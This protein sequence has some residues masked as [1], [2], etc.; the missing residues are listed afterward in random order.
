MPT[1]SPLHIVVFDACGLRISSSHI[2][3][4][5]PISAALQQ[6]HALHWA[7]WRVKVK[8]QDNLRAVLTRLEQ[9]SDGAIVLHTAERTYS[10]ARALAD[11]IDDRA[12]QP[13]G[14]PHTPASPPVG[15]AAT[16]LQQ[17][18]SQLD[19]GES[20]G[21]S[22]LLF[23]YLPGDTILCSRR[24]P[25]L[26]VFPNLWTCEHTEIIEPADVVANRVSLVF[27]R[28]LQEELPC[29]AGFGSPRPVALGVRQIARNWQLVGVLDL[30]DLP[31][32]ALHSAL[33]QLPLNEETAAW[34][35]WH[36]R[37]EDDAMPPCPSWCPEVLWS[38]PADV[39]RDVDLAIAVRRRLSSSVPA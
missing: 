29:L 2:H 6:Q 4:P 22:A 26:H 7:R 33:V 17:A 11:A 30:S 32:A 1:H 38:Q 25:R 13:A 24:G 31:M 34:C 39:P 20:W 15:E 23:V 5:A 28:V 21:L 12:L 35:A 36:P 9:S 19:P 14:S 37:M 8:G 3:A 16:P 10:E 18:A 27:R